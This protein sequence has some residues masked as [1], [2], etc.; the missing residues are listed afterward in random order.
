MQV[1]GEVEQMVVRP[2]GWVYAM[3]QRTGAVHVFDDNGTRRHVCR[4]DVAGEDTDASFESFAVSREGEV[5]VKRSARAGSVS[6]KDEFIR[7]SPDGSRIGVMA[8][9]VKE[10]SQTWHGQ[11]GSSNLWVAGYEDLYLVDHEGK[12]LRQVQRLADR[13]WLLGP[14]PVAAAPDGSIAVVSVVEPNAYGWATPDG[15]RV[16]IYS[17][18]AKAV[19]TSR[20]PSDF[21]PVQGRLAYD[22]RSMAFLTES[23]D[24]GR[25]RYRVVLADARGVQRS[26][27]RPSDLDQGAALFLLD[28]PKG[29]ELWLFDGEAIRRYALH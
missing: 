15:W 23:D 22:G 25:S 4:P 2:N 19:H 27:F 1:L 3:D 24:Q 21:V 13:R 6:S 26:M 7:F 29:R 8:T 28:R 12:I 5:F 20:V 16:T 9:N 10:S 14:V 17:R 18:D 11:P